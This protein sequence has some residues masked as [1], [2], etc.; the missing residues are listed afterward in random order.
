MC[1]GMHGGE[2]GPWSLSPLFI[3]TLNAP[4]V[5]T[6]FN[7][8]SYHFE[9]RWNVHNTWLEIEHI[10]YA[11]Y[12][13]HIRNEGCYTCDYKAI[14]IVILFRAIEAFATQNFIFKTILRY[15]A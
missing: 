8:L 13:I 1:N 12:I 5:S 15:L 14:N 6:I 11:F 9:V 7:E 4:F 3:T 2:K 10:V